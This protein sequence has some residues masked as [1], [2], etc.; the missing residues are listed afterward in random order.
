MD[1][2]LE[3]RGIIYRYIERERRRE[4]SIIY[5]GEGAA[6]LTGDGGYPLPTDYR[7]PRQTIQNL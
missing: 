1:G 6:L 3:Y 4:I 7:N 2:I 5:S